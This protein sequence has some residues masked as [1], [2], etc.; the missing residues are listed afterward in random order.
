MQPT[1][2]RP[3]SEE[4]LLD[5]ASTSSR[6]LMD[7][8]R[9]SS[10]F[11]ICAG[12]GSCPGCTRRCQHISLPAELLT[13][14]IVSSSGHRWSADESKDIDIVKPMRAGSS[15]E[16]AILAR[17]LIRPGTYHQLWSKSEL[18]SETGKSSKISPSFLADR[19]GP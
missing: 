14:A 1:Q 13:R 3:A 9:N 11:R 8:Q 7:E 18:I 16:Q 2:V 19:K 6:R 17:H 15:R 5:P 10:F 12:H 4:V